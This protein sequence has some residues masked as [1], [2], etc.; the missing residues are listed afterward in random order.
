MRKARG[1]LVITLVTSGIL[2]FSGCSAPMKDDF[3]DLRKSHTS[4]D[5]LPALDE[6][7][8][9]TID[10]ST[11]RYV[12]E[13]E[14]TSLWIAEGIETS[15]ICLVALFGDSE[16]SISC[17]GTSGVATQGPAGSFAV[18]PDGVFAPDNAMKISENVY[19]IMP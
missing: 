8:S 7:P 16:G 3:A 12:G 6:D 11:T 17:G 13:H 5:K 15:S 2:A 1:L 19:A 14:G 10:P 4:E 9:D 18:I